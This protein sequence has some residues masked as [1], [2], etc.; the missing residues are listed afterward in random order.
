MGTTTLRRR[1]VAYTAMRSHT[2]I[3]RGVA[4]PPLR[5]GPFSQS[6]P[7]EKVR[8]NRSDVVAGK[9][10]AGKATIDSDA[11]RVSL[12]FHTTLDLEA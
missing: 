6:V 8:R 9:V 10:T 7:G 1:Q 5:L 4:Q 3:A 11:A 12:S 2:A